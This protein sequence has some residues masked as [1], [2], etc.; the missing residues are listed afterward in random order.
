MG[1]GAG[2]G[3]PCA[4][5][6]SSTTAARLAVAARAETLPDD[7]SADLS[8]AFGKPPILA[9]IYSS[10]MTIPS[11]IGS[12]PLRSAPPRHDTTR[13]RLAREAA[14]KPLPTSTRGRSH[15]ARARTFR[16][17]RQ[18]APHLR[19]C[20]SH[21][22][23]A[24]APRLDAHDRVSLV[25]PEY[26]APTDAGLGN[27]RGSCPPFSPNSRWLPS[28]PCLRNRPILHAVAPA[29]LSAISA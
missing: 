17:Q 9:C 20:A 22:V 14:A 24:E 21:R 10:S 13:C 26:R 23:R 25:G 6:S 29:P 19:L 8:P 16:C 28:L 27:V 15:E 18:T 11:S 2:C 3:P 12:R 7:A 4:A 5:G 1:S